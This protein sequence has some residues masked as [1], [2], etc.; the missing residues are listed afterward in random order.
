[1][2]LENTHNACNGSPLSAE[3]V[4]DVADLT[5]QH[6]LK[7]HIDGARIFNAA[8]ALQVPVDQLVKDADS[9]TFCLSKGLCAPVGSLICGSA[10]YIQNVIRARKVLGGGMRQAGVLAAAGIV[11]LEQMTE[12][13]VEDH[14]RAGVLRESFDVV[15]WINAG[16]A[17][18]NIF[19][20]TL[21]E[22]APITGAELALQLKDKGILLPNRGPNSFRVVT[23]YWFDDDALATVQAAIRAI[24]AVYN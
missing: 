23:H 22:D 24:A 18:T 4:S 8:A 17:Y 20:F 12:R 2:C 13:L 7:L 5:H 19:Y 11:A 10:V 3:Y 6:H 16:P 15:P 14:E 21:S 1:V 9:V